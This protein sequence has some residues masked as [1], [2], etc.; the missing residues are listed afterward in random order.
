MTNDLTGRQDPARLNGLN[1]LNEPRELNEDGRNRDE[2]DGAGRDATPKHRA[3]DRGGEQAAHG[4][5]DTQD[6]ATPPAA[7]TVA[8]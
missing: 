8:P 3:E 2:V 6:G 1:G 5:S 7:D 4:A